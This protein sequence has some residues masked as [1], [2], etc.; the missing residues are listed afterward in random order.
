MAVGG[1]LGTVARYAVSRALPAGV[2]SFPWATFWTN[3]SGA[4][5]LGVLLTL[6]L[7]RWPPTRY[8]RPFAATG[9]VGAYTTWSTFMVETDELLAHGHAATALAY[10]GASLVV[11]LAAVTLGIAVGRLWPT[12]PADTSPS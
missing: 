1:A 11:G 10:V 7:E 2:A 3:V 8:V 6:I 4:F 5:V 12:T 9:F